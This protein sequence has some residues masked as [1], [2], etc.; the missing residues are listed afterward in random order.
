LEQATTE[1]TPAEAT[2]TDAKPKASKPQQFVVEFPTEPAARA[3]VKALEEGSGIGPYSITGPTREGGMRLTTQLTDDQRDFAMTIVHTLHGE[4]RKKVEP[5]SSGEVAK[6]EKE[7]KAAK[8]PKVKEPKEPKPPK[9]PRP[10]AKDNYVSCPICGKKKRN[11]ATLKNHVDLR[12]DPEKEKRRKEREER[13]QAK[14]KP[15][16]KE[17][18]KK[19]EKKPE[20]K[21]TK[22]P[23]KKTAAK[24]KKRK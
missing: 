8:E 16:E 20:K 21:A 24:P 18:P 11:E 7:P 9:E 12:H 14:E 10:R 1:E 4:A 5:A 15:V 23:S 2:P 3:F 19:E 13:K 6:E 17:E 22:K